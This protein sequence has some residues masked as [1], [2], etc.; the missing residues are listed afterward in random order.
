MKNTTVYCGSS[1]GNEEL[2]NNQAFSLGETLANQDLTLVNGGANIG[3]MG[4][5]GKV[6][7]AL[8]TFLQSLEIAHT[9][10]SELILV[11]SLHDRKA[12]MFEISDG[13]IALSGGFGTM[14]ELFEVLTLAQLGLYKKP[15]ALINVAGYF[16]P[17][18]TMLQTMVN[19]G[20]LKKVQQESL[21]VSDNTAQLIGNMHNY[22]APTEGKCIPQPSFEK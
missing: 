14:D 11:D 16:D 5:G 6:I 1:K 22:A 4:A 17:Q 2:F 19:I 8:T 12:K 13:V 7:G 20:F 10:L 18:L 21:L 3:L 15:T 9:V